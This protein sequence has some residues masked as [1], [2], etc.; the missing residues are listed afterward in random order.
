MSVPKDIISS[1]CA[2]LVHGATH[3]KS[4]ARI[5]TQ[6]ARHGIIVPKVGLE[7]GASNPEDEALGWGM[8][9]R[10]KHVRWM[11]VLRYHLGGDFC[12][13]LRWGE[14]AVRNSHVE[15]DL[16]LEL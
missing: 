13:Y 7:A 5:E 8:V 15:G 16:L 6:V 10:L 4:E 2:N 9:D 11:P 14:D 12:H 1:S 3:R